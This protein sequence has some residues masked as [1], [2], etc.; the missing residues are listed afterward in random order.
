MR[1]QTRSTGP[2]R[3]YYACVVGVRIS[4]PVYTPHL[5]RRGCRCGPH[6]SVCDARVRALVPDADATGLALDARLL[7]VGSGALQMWAH[8]RAPCTRE[9]GAGN[10]AGVLVFDIPAPRAVASAESTMH[11]SLC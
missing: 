8:G 3:S 9:D 7:T 6:A 1:T 5:A 2:G 10:A 4:A 11:S